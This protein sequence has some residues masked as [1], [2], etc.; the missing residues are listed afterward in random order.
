ML[1]RLGASLLFLTLVALGLA[2]AFDY[3]FH[4]PLETAVRAELMANATPGRI[5]I[6][7]LEALEKDDIEEADM[8]AD[9][10]KYLNYE[11]PVDT[12]R[13]IDEAHSMSATVVR[14]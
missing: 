6:K 9:I 7:I 10:G 13:R 3:T 8:Y 2:Y 5:N 12:Q 11:I 1:S 4:I 14:N